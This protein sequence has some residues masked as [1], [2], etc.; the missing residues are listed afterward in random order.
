VGVEKSW[1]KF[2]P[3]LSEFLDC[4]ITQSFRGWGG[5]NRP[6]PSESY[7]LG[8]FVTLFLPVLEGGSEG[9][10]SDGRWKVRK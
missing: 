6:G 4:Y 8:S 10:T 7:R 5:E 2:S 9:T 1:S 3:G